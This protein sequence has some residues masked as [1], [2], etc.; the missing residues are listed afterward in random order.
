MVSKSSDQEVITL[1]TSE[2]E[3]VY[4]S[5]RTWEELMIPESI[6]RNLMLKG[7]THPTLIQGTAIPIINNG[8]N[9]IA[10][11]KNGTGKTGTFVIG[12]LSRV[13]PEIKAL[14]VICLSHTRELNQQNFAVFQEIANNIG[15]DV[16]LVQKGDVNLPHCQV[17]CGTH[18][19]IKRVIRGN[20]LSH[21]KCIVYDEADF[22][23]S[24]EDNL[25]TISAI[26]SQ[27]P[28]AQQLLFSA[29]FP[30]QVWQFVNQ[31]IQNPFQIKIEKQEDLT[32]DNVGQYV[33][34]CRKQEKFEVV[35]EI[36]RKSDLRCC[37]IFINTKKYLDSLFQFLTQKGNKVFIVASGTVSE[38]DRDKILDKVRKG[39]V[40]VLLA[41]NLLSR[42]IDLRNVNLVINLD[43]PTGPNKEPDPVTYLHR[44]GRTGRYG[45][46]GIAINIVSDPM[47]QQVFA[48]IQ[49]HYTQ[50]FEAITVDDLSEKLQ[51]VNKDYEVSEI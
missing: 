49:E 36:I 47:S 12:S 33:I 7:W 2:G 25:K 44:V 42:G 5:S 43:P 35:H 21:V 34:Q 51:Q 28:S 40:N 50:R 14:Q 23:F 18:G 32:L 38:E 16:C 4:A 1:T 29:T 9:I 8:K 27:M 37:I 31:N 48:Q 30:A 45:R 13:N 20:D 19:T 6:E 17:L 22:M 39:E 11:S 26:R 15:V 46:G 41:T 10:Q 3:T 24:H